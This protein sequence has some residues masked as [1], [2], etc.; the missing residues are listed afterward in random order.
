MYIFV[1]GIYIRVRFKN[2]KIATSI[3][4]VQQW[5]KNYF[6]HCHTTSILVARQPVKNV[7]P[8]AMLRVYSYGSTRS[9]AMHT[10]YYR[11]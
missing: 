5:R 4:V 3:L 10:K 1:M 8:I 9:M 7:L 11:F 6:A 2:K